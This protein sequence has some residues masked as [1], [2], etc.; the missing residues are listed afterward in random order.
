MRFRMSLQEQNSPQQ[1]PAGKRLNKYIAETGYCSRREADRLIAERRV[2][3]NGQP[4]TI[5][6]QVV[7]G[8]EVR[9]DGQPLQQRRVD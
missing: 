4:G 2:T 9:I 7:E 6:S 8:D 3:L 1:E 5:G